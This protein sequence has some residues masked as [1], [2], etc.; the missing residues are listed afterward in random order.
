MGA[1]FRG[2]R[3]QP[4]LQGVRRVRDL[5]H[6]GQRGLGFGECGRVAVIFGQPLLQG[7]TVGGVEPAAGETGDP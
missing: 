4:D 5:I 3:R 2:W 6:Q 1:P 7:T